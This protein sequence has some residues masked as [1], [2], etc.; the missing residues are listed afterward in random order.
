MDSDI[1]AESGNAEGTTSGLRDYLSNGFKLR[2]THGSSNT[3]GSTYV[4][5]AFAASPFVTSNG[6]PTNAR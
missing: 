2:G 3:D 5:A 6:A 1:Q 4:Y